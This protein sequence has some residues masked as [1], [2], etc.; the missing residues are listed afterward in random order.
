M[1]MLRVREGKKEKKEDEFGEEVRLDRIEFEALAEC[2]A[3][4]ARRT[5]LYQDHKK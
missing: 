4:G 3:P 5:C 1:D 2:F